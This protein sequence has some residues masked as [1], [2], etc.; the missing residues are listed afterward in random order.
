L[1]E[2]GALLRQE[3]PGFTGRTVF[4]SVGIAAQDLALAR[5]AT[6]KAM[7]IGGFPTFDL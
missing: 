5:L 7:A 4:K 6:E 3:R 1:V 2:I